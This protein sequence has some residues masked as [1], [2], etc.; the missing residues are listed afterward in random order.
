MI[1][2]ASYYNRA[3]FRPGVD[4]L[5][6]DTRAVFRYDSISFE[7]EL[8]SAA[9]AYVDRLCR[10]LGDEIGLVPNTVTDAYGAFT[11]HV[12][13][14]LGALDK[15]GFLTECDHRPPEI[16]LSGSQFWRQVE[17]FSNRA[18]QR[19]KPVLFAALIGGRVRRGS[20]IRY[21]QE[22]YHLVRHG[23]AIIA[24]MLAHVS[25]ARTQ[26]MLSRFLVQELGHERLLLQSLKGAG[27]TD[28]EIAASVPL[29]ETFA[30]IACLQTLA[31]QDPLSFK[32]V[33]FLLEQASPE[34]HSALREASEKVGLDEK[35][36][37]PIIRHAE[38]ND[39]GAHES[40]SADLLSEVSTVEAEERIVALVHVASLIES[41]V[42]LEHAVLDAKSE[43]IPRA[44]L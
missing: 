31:D 6:G 1:A 43:L 44:C 18:K 26:L 13:E 16:P 22:Y 3:A 17:A 42:G 27:L 15:Y 11:P 39:D 38:I 33:A 23:P 5:V 10:D 30:L 2:S 36:W 40:I 32:A 7:V 4:F 37:S 29:P 25:S 41:L 8:N 34:F 35:F 28:T 19:F 20:L 24:G 12:W 9:A 14:I 21:A